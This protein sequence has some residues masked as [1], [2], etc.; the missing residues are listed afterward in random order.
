MRNS[1]TFTPSPDIGLQSESRKSA[2]RLEGVDTFRTLAILGVVCIHTGPFLKDG[3]IPDSLAD[4]GLIINQLSRFAVPYFFVIAGYFWGRKLH[5][6]ADIMATSAAT[7]RRIGGVFLFWC[8]IYLLPLDLGTIWRRG[9]LGPF[10]ALQSN[11]DSLLHSYGPG[12]VLVGTKDHLWFLPALICVVFISAFFLARGWRVALAAMALILFLTGLAAKAYVDSPVGLDIPFDTR[13]GPFLGL[14][15]FVFGEALSRFRPQPR[16]LLLGGAI[17]VTGYSLQ[18]GELYLLQHRFGTSPLQDYVFGTALTG[19]GAALIA[20]SNVRILRLP[21]LS[22]LG[23]YVL[24]IYAVQY[25]FVDLLKPLHAISPFLDVMQ[26]V[27]VFALSAA[28]VL[29]LAANRLTARFVT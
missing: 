10:D 5:A 26:V 11:L 24:G 22:R 15:L 20:L 12:I 7:I 13:N 1:A 2:A 6:G 29:V 19:F 18:F 23:P 21:V 16:W 8:A 28:A 9:A 14:I 4:P 17:L 27:L 3:A 25:V